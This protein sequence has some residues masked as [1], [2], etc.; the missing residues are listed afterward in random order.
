MHIFLHYNTHVNVI[1]SALTDTE[2]YKCPA[3]RVIF[4]QKY[5]YLCSYSIAPLH[6]GLS[7]IVHKSNIRFLYFAKLTVHRHHLKILSYKSILS[8]FLLQNFQSLLNFRK[9]ILMFTNFKIDV[10]RKMRVFR[11]SIIYPFPA[12]NQLFYAQ[13]QINSLWDL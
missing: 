3:A 6:W 8:K 2:A 10:S 9:R 1:L 12:K 13:L 5:V 7:Y 11:R 4:P